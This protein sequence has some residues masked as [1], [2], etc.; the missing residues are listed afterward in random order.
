MHCTA[1][2]DVK[3]NCVLDKVVLT[4]TICGTVCEII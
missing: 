1:A 2:T 3:G 4:Y